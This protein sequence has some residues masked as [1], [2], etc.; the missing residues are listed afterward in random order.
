MNNRR[1]HEMFLVFINFVTSV[2]GLS[3]AAYCLSTIIQLPPYNCIF[4]TCNGNYL[5]SNLNTIN[6][7]SA[8]ATTIAQICITG[9]LIIFLILRSH[10][11]KKQ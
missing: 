3:F 11:I 1:G 8:S 7:L 2:I 6:F 5:N 4:N 9:I 10:Y